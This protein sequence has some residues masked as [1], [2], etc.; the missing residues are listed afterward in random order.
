MHLHFL[1]PEEAE[2]EAAKPNVQ[3]SSEGP[4]KC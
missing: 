4:R 1:G 3:T 2:H